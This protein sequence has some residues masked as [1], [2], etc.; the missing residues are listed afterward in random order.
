MGKIAKPLHGKPAHERTLEEFVGKDPVIDRQYGLW[1]E[2]AFYLFRLPFLGEYTLKAQ[3]IFQ[4]RPTVYG[5]SDP[6][7]TRR[8]FHRV[9][10][11]VLETEP[12]YALLVVDTIDADT[13][14][15][16]IERGVVG[17]FYRDDFG[18]N[19][20]G[21]SEAYRGKGIAPHFGNRERGSLRGLFAG[22][23]GDEKESAP[24]PRG[25]RDQAW[26]LGAYPGACRAFPS[27]RA[28]PSAPSVHG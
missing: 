11:G 22:G 1:K 24:D 15:V 26:G 14:K 7:V 23:T 28:K 3:D 5:T 27:L 17:E 12:T 21:I 8:L 10:V 4:T 18:L 16:F 13:G 25:E 6:N 2:E 9:H 20:L 19:I